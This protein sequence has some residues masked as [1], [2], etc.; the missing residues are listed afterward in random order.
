MMRR[1]LLIIPGTALDICIGRGRPSSH[2]RISGIRKI[3]KD[4]FCLA[5]LIRRQ[6]LAVRT[7]IGRQL[8]FVEL[9]GRIQHKL[10]VITEF[11]PGH[12][13]QVATAQEIRGLP[14]FRRMVP[15]TAYGEGWALYAEQLAWEAGFQK[16]P[17]TNLGRLQAEMFRAVRLVVDTGIHAMRWTREQAIAYMLDNTGMPEI[18]VIAEIERYFVMPG[19]ALAYKVGMIKILDLRAKAKAALG[20]KF[21]IRDFHDAVLKN[22]GMPLSILE[23]VVDQY[24]ADKRGAAPS[25]KS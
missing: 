19:Q 16:D 10:R 15:F 9:L 2:R 3:G 12:H 18:E 20:E 17:F 8:L 23:R 4:D 6:I 24:I 7:R 1:N 22:G 14:I 11:L 5:E 25:A 13:L 21:D